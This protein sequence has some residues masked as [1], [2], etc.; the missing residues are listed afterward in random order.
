MYLFAP[1]GYWMP[2]APPAEEVVPGGD[3]V[4]WLFAYFF[5]LFGILWGTEVASTFLLRALG[6]GGGP[7]RLGLGTQEAIG[8]PIAG[9]CAYF[10]V[11]YIPAPLPRA[12]ISPTGVRLY[13]PLRS[14]ELPWSR[15]RLVG[16]HVYAFTRRGDV[17]QVYRANDYQ[18]SRLAEFA[19]N[20]R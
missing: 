10:F 15:V 12:A 5:T 17:S 3:S 4:G 11:T 1:S 9:L 19:P 20:M 16:D 18:L 7:T 13:F 6:V 8:V 2:P 14:V